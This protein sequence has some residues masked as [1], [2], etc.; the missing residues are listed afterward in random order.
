[1]LTPGRAPPAARRAS[2]TRDPAGSSTI[3]GRR[4]FPATST[5]TGA[6]TLAGRRARHRWGPQPVARSGSRGLSRQWTAGCARW[7][8]APARAPEATAGPTKQ[9]PRRPRPQS[10]QRR[11]AGEPWRFH[12]PYSSARRATCRPASIPRQQLDAD[13]ER[14][15]RASLDPARPR[16]GR[17][18]GRRATRS[19]LNRLSVLARPSRVA[20]AAVGRAPR[21]L[22]LRCQ[23]GQPPP[24]DCACVTFGGG[25]STE[26]AATLGGDRPA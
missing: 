11:P 25:T 9:R 4:T 22:E 13:P 18:L 24:R 10:Q 20:V 7:P 17:L 16:C 19:A 8:V 3:P 12:L 1:M 5:M 21:G 14:R 6:P 2:T 23:R 15:H 26:H